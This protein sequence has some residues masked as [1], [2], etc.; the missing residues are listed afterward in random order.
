LVFGLCF[1]ISFSITFYFENVTPDLLSLTGKMHVIGKILGIS[2][3]NDGCAWYVVGLHWNKI[4]SFVTKR[5]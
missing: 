4:D 2:N 3:R 5:R 1:E